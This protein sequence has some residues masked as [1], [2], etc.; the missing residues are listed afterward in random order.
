MERRWSSVGRTE[1]G[2]A[3]SARYMLQ[4][5]KHT[6]RRVTHSWLKWS[7]DRNRRSHYSA[8]IDL[9][10]NHCVL[11][12]HESSEGFHMTEAALSSVGSEGAAAAATMQSAA[13]CAAH[14]DPCRPLQSTCIIH[15]PDCFTFM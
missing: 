4:T 5:Y 9:S 3:E 2:L 10:V 1:S 7:L 11:L 12:V 13:E 14:A 8:V 15:H 6:K